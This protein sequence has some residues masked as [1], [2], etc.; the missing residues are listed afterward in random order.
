MGV[1]TLFGL[2]LLVPG[3]LGSDHWILELAIHWQ[4]WVSGALVLPSVWFA[5][6][7]RWIWF[8][9]ALI[10]VALGVR[11]AW[12]YVAGELEVAQRSAVDSERTMG[13]ATVNLFSNLSDTADVLDWIVSEKVDV[14]AIQEVTHESVS[15][16]KERLNATLP[17]QLFQSGYGARGMGFASRWPIDEI[18][19]FGDTRWTHVQFAVTV[20]TPTGK[21]R[22]FSVHP[23]NPTTRPQSE[24][25]RATLGRI[26]QRISA[27][28]EPV[29]V[30]GDFNLT[31]WSPTFRRF[32]Q[33]TQLRD[34]RVGRGLFPTWSPPSSPW[35]L[36]PIDH[37]LVSSGWA[38]DRLELGP[39][40]GSDHRPLIARLVR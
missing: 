24:Q 9:M 27:A 10:G 25:Q 40:F 11:V 38:L 26:A 15:F 32:L 17:H 36:I 22:C 16:V 3:L 8:A 39:R 20:N 31:P 4:L 29:V 35:P 1:C 19:R 14:V 12:P 28:E 37:I 23:T 21:V 34:P 33:T 2:A 5:V 13:V 30:V 18:E 6:R 7:R